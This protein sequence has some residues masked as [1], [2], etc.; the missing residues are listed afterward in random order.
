M[1]RMMKDGNVI[2]QFKGKDKIMIPTFEK[3]SR[4][5]DTKCQ[6]FPCIIS[7]EHSFKMIKM[8]PFQNL[9]GPTRIIIVF[10][11]SLQNQNDSPTISQL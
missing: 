10:L 7:R 8:E 11:A 9:R 2:I 6:K 4:L 1:M 3:S 5:F